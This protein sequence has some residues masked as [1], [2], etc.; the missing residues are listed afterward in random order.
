LRVF[1]RVIPFDVT[2]KALTCD[3]AGRADGKVVSK[4]K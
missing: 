2:N 3:E 4:V 1:D